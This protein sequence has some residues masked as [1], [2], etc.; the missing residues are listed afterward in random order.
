[1][2]RSSQRDPI[3][4]EDMGQDDN[5]RMPHTSLAHP[6]ADGAVRLQDW[7]VILA[8]GADAAVFLN[9]QLTQD[10]LH[11]ESARASLAGYCSPK[12]RLLAT[13]VAWRLSADRFALAC[14][15]DLLPATLKRLSMHVLRAKCKLSDASEAWPLHG[16]AGPSADAALGTALPNGSWACAAL[17]GS[18]VIRLPAVD[19]TS[20][21]LWAGP[22]VPPLPALDADAWRWLEV[23]SG[24]PRVS[25]A[26]ADQF[27][28]QMLNLELLGGVNFKKGCYPGQEI[29]ARSQYRGTLKRRTY[30]MA[31]DAALAA[32][33]EVFHS[34]DPG[35]PAG[36]VVLGA[37][38]PGAA[39]AALVELKMAAL[40]GGTLHAGSVHGP[41][42]RRSTLPYTLDAIAD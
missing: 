12:G 18:C 40:L 7:G 22:D 9:G 17:G 37:S 6:I 16:L 29:V 33:A 19:A 11:L 3:D 15:A 10:M 26:T 2:A 32:G 41:H 13:F 21:Y 28:P 8:E 23:H 30:L 35:Q 1:M 25:A 38:L 24:L 27:V 39:H 42:L 34:E 14:S 5:C 36:M 4:V 20:R 31:C